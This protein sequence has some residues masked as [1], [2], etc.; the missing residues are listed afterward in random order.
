MAGLRKIC[1][2]R[3]TRTWLYRIATNQCLD[4][5]RSTSR[6]WA[7]EWDV[8][9]VGPPEPTRLGEVVWIEPYPDSHLD[10]SIDLP[11]GPDARYTSRGSR[12]AWLS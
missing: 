2:T 6:R 5:R 10:G 4:A 8:P 12:S 7:K 9:N 3:L 1:R 11:L